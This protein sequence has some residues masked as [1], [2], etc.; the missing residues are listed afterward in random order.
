DPGAVAAEARAEVAKFDST[1]AVSHVETMDQ[2]LSESLAQ[3]RF[4][5]L[6]LGLFAVLALVLAAVGIYGVVSYGVVRRTREIGIRMALGGQ[7]RAMN[8]MIIRRGLRLAFVGAA[9]GLVGALALERVVQSLLF[10][11][12]PADPTILCGVTLL[13]FGTVVAACYLPGRRAM[14]VDPIAALREE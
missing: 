10:E 9:I 8:R 13:L 5:T 7:P 4:S 3:Q 11:V 12:K 2:L 14:R 1:L 6:L